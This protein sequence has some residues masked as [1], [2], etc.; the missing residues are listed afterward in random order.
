MVVVGGLWREALRT[1]PSSSES[2]SSNSNVIPF[3]RDSDFADPTEA[4]ER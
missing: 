2:G 4:S 1:Q 3:D